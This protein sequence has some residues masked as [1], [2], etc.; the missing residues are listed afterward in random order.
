MRSM[1]AF[2]VAG[3]GQAFDF[4]GHQALG[5]EADHLAQQIGTEL[6]SKR[7]RRANVIVIVVSGLGQV[8]LAITH[9]IPETAMAARCG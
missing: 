9:P 1:R 6:F 4:Q 2:A 8:F 5:G 7:P 3:A